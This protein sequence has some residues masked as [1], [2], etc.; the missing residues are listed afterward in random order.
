MNIKDHGENTEGNEINKKHDLDKIYD[1]NNNPK[2]IN[3]I[4]LDEIQENI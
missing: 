1:G 4:N 2:K 3:L